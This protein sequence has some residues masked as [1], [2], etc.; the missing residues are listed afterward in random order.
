[1]SKIGKDVLHVKVPLRRFYINLDSNKLS[2]FQTDVGKILVVI[3]KN[4]INT[5][6]VRI[7]DVDLAVVDLQSYS[8]G[9]LKQG[10]NSG[11][12]YELPGIRTTNIDN[13]IK[14]SKWIKEFLVYNGGEYISEIGPEFY[15]V[16]WSLGNVIRKFSKLEPEQILITVQNIN[17]NITPEQLEKIMDATRKIL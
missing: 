12:F 1:M 3:P 16:P 6:G 15:L 9:Y 4:E 2:A 8:V 11:M 10:H 13:R 5:I 17:P 7:P 14:I